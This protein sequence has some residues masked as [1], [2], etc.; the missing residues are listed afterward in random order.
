M[1]ELDGPKTTKTRDEERE[2]EGEVDASSLWWQTAGNIMTQLWLDAN[3]DIRRAFPCFTENKPTPVAQNFQPPPLWC[4][5]GALLHTLPSSGPTIQHA[6]EDPS[7]ITR[8]FSKERKYGKKKYFLHFHAAGPRRLQR[9][10]CFDLI[11]IFFSPMVN[12]SGSQPTRAHR[13]I[14]QIEAFLFD[15]PGPD[16]EGFSSRRSSSSGRYRRKVKVKVTC[17]HEPAI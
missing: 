5:L 1:E 12:H 4:P 3:S 2:E 14:Q 17:K 10:I 8:D 7:H 16:S 11:N 9:R 6:H 15:A 13:S